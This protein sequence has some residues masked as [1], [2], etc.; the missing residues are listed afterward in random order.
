MGDPDAA[1]RPASG[2]TLVEFSL[3]WMLLIVLYLFTGP[4]G[5]GPV[6]VAVSWL[7]I[8]TTIFSLI[9]LARRFP[10]FGYFLVAFVSGLMSGG[11]RRR[12]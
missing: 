11:R 1:P 7:L 4:R 8:G 5:F 10:L 9:V 12:W 6:P 3:L 2:I